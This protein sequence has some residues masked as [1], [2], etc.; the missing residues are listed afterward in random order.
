MVGGG[1]TENRVR[2]ETRPEWLEKLLERKSVFQTYAGE[3]YAHHHPTNSFYVEVTRD[4]EI[5]FY[6][7]WDYKRGM[8]RRENGK[9][10]QSEFAR[11]NVERDRWW[12]AL[13]EAAC[14]V[15]RT[16]RQ[17]DWNTIL[18]FEGNEMDVRSSFEKYRV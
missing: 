15:R 14:F 9:M 8:E 12:V 4:G 11:A 16:R 6:D 10:Q 5:L 13:A 18:I 1:T 2:P 3:Y 7:G 17:Y